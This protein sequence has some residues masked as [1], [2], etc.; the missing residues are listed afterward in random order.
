MKKVI[1]ALALLA[2]LSACQKENYITNN[3]PATPSIVGATVTLILNG[4]PAPAIMTVSQALHQL[5]VDVTVTEQT[6]LDLI[7]TVDGKRLREKYVDLP[8]GS[9]HL[10]VETDF[11]PYKSV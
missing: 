7:L 5:E 1:L 10:R 4:Q 11:I 2:T 3:S 8:A 6:H 9:Y